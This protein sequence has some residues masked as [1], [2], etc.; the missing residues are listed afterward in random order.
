MVISMVNISWLI[1][2]NINICLILI[3]ASGEYITG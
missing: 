3:T 2:V 1:M